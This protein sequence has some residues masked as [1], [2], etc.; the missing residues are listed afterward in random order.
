MKPGFWS[1]YGDRCCEI[2]MPLVIGLTMHREVKPNRF[3]IPIAAKIV[4]GTVFGL[5]A[6]YIIGVVLAFTLCPGLFR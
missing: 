6:L 1:R 4:L 5:A 2:R 3:E